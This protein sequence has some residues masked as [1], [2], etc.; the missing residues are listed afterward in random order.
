M[1]FTDPARFA[2]AAIHDAEIK[3][4][5]RVA[6]FGLGAIGML[7]IQMA[8]LD[9]AT[10]VIAID[11]I[12]ERLELANKLGADITINPQ[13]GDA[14]IAIKEATGGRGVDVA[15]EISGVYASLQQ[16]IRSAHKEGLVVTASYY[17]DRTTPVDLSREWHH[18][19][20]TSALQHAGMGL[21]TPQAA[22]VGP[23]PPGADRGLFIGTAKT[24]N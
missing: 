16:A 23:R 20:L 13:D 14:A 11:P 7:A 6:I 10:Q 24:E 15:V 17:G 8:R 9:G 19:R 21:L 2:L 12:P 3:L 22:D 5:D 4:G 18:N 1:V